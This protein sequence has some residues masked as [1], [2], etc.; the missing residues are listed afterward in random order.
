MR[1]A[2]N[3][4][5]FSS[6]SSSPY[7]TRLGK[8]TA[9]KA[10]EKNHLT[11]VVDQRSVGRQDEVVFLEVL[12][13][14]LATVRTCRTSGIAESVSSRHRRG[15]DERLTVVD[16]DRDIVLFDLLFDL[17]L[18]LLQQSQRSQDE[19]RLF[20]RVVARVQNARRD[21]FDRLPETLHKLTRHEG[22]R[23]RKT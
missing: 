21:R 2:F 20:A 12:D 13:L 23:L 10:D 14:V 15:S 22:Q 3:L 7:C 16:Q 1:F 4:A 17:V 9:Y 8:P 19:G 11:H 5:F 18:P 6:D